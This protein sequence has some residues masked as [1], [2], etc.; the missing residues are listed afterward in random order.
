MVEKFLNIRTETSTEEG[1]GRTFRG[2]LMGYITANR[3]WEAGETSTD[4]IRPVYISFAC[5]E[6][7]SHPFV[8]NLQMGR[9]MIVDKGR[10]GDKIELLRS[11]GY[12]FLYQRMEGG[13]VAVQ[14]YLPEL[15]RLDPGMVDPDSIKF[16][17]APTLE[18]L[19]ESSIPTIDRQKAAQHVASLWRTRIPQGQ[20]LLDLV[21]SAALFCAYLDRRTNCPMIQDLRFQLQVFLAALNDGY[22]TL[23]ESCSGKWG[24]HRNIRGSKQEED[25]FSYLGPHFGFKDF[26]MDNCKLDIPVAFYSTH[27]QIE[28]FLAEQVEIYFNHVA[29][30]ESIRKMMSEPVQK[31]VGVL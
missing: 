16:V 12:D 23:P 13:V 17:M 28:A 15:V 31:A 25:R 10:H 11:V 1:K 3:L 29:W 27:E 21:P 19:R 14:A 30:V 4:K 7:E 22:A 18:W 20:E 9:C 6:G 5:S 2:V 24:Y 8:A 26:G